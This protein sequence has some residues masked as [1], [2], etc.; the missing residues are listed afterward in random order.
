MPVLSSFTQDIMFAAGHQLD[1]HGA[2]GK[3]HG[4]SYTVSLTFTGVPN[5]NNFGYPF[6]QDN[7]LKA[8][9]IVLELQNRFLPD[10]LPAGFPSV[11]GVAAYLME[12]TQILGVSKVEVHESDTNVTGTAEYIDR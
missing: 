3:L 10:M 8:T 7:L 2:C 6:E 1:G 12:R 4:H 11:S 9:A 5:R